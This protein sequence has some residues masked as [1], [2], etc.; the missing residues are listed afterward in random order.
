MTWRLLLVLCGFCLG[1]SCHP[2][3]VPADPARFQ[4]VHRERYAYQRYDDGQVAVVAKS[5]RDLD[6]AL[7]EIGCGA[8]YVCLVEPAGE[9][10]SVTQR[11]K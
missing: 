3:H 10:F 5:P 7:D 6:Q 4:P 8:E 9:Y 2:K 1:V 11:K